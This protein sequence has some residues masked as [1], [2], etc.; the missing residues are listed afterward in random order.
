MVY[1]CHGVWCADFHSK[2]NC[3][4][5]FICTFVCALLLAVLGRIRAVYVAF[6]AHT[7][8]SLWFLA[9]ENHSPICTA[10]FWFGLNMRDVVLVKYLT[11]LERAEVRHLFWTLCMITS[12]VCQFCF[13]LAGC[14]ESAVQKWEINVEY[15][16][17]MSNTKIKWHPPVGCPNY[18]LTTTH[19][20]FSV[21]L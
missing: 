2:C 18:F 19:M 16:D 15:R 20:Y 14:V 11:W 10:C 7:W 6:S 8:I 17:Q 5:V 12:A 9:M 13:S 3:F 1:L 4:P 21:L